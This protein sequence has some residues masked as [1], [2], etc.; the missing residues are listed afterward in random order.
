LWESPLLGLTLIEESFCPDIRFFEF[1]NKGSAMKVR[2][3]VPVR[4]LIVAFGLAAGFVAT[5]AAG[6][7][8]G[9][10]PARDQR[11]S[12]LE[13]QIKELNRKLDDLRK[14]TPVASTTAA[15]DG[16]I[17]TDW[18][19]SLSWR[20]IGPAN[21]G[22]RITA[23]SVFEADP[24]TYWVATASGGLLKTVN[25][26]ITFEHQFDHEATVS[27]GD[28]CVAPSD[29]N[30]VWVG[31][32]E[33]NPRNSVSYGDGV[34][35][36][37]DGGKTWKNMGLKKTYQVGRIVVDPKDPNIVYV[38]ALGR[39]Y[40]PNEERGVFKTADGGRTWTKTLYID[41][42]TGIIDL[43]INPADPKTLLAAA[44]E[45]QRDE[46]DDFLGEPPP[47]D[48]VERYDPVRKYGKG[49]GIYKS[50]D[51]GATWKKMTQGLP[52]CALG[53][54]GLDYYRKDPKVVFAVIDT[55][56]YGT[57]LPP[58]A[59]YMGVQGTEEKTGTKLVD[60]AANSPADQAGLKVSDVLISMDGKPVANQAALVELLRP[61]KVGDKIKAAYQR[62]SEKKEVEVALAARPTPGGGAGGP[63]FPNAGFF[64]EDAEGGALVTE[65]EE[66]GPAAQAGLKIDDV[67]TAVEG[68]PVDRF[69]L[70]IGRLM[71]THRAGDKI[72]ISLTR[73]TEKKDISVPLQ[74]GGFERMRGRN[75]PGHTKRPNNGGLGGQRENIQDQQGPDGFQTGGI[76]KS[77][78]GGETWKRINSLNPRPMYFSQV[79]VDPSDEKIIWV[80]GVSL[81]CSKDG[82]KTFRDE[83]NR[84]LHSDQHALWIDPHNGRHMII[85]CDGGF[86]H[87]YDRA[88][89]WDHLNH[90]ALGQFYHVA[91]DPR[92]LYR[93][94]GGLQD[95]GSWGGPAQM[96][97]STG[98]VNEDWI[99]VGGG[100]GFV[101][102]VDPS[103]PEL[104]YSESQGGAMQ[105]RN[106]KTGERAPIRP[107]RTPGKPAHRFN[108]NTPYIL[109]SHNPSIFYCAGE[110]VWR[111]VKRGDRLRTISPEITRTKKG[112]AT[113]LAESPKNP[114]VL[115]VGTDDG[116]LWITRDGGGKWTEV[117]GKVGLPGPRW[118]ATIEPSRHVEGRAYVAFDAHRSNDDEPYVYVTEDYGETWKSIHG[119][120]PVGSTRVCREDITNQDLLYVGTEFGAWVSANRGVSWTKLNNNLPT[121]AVHEFAQHSTAGEMVAATHGR[122]LWV[123]DVTPLRQ[124]TKETL[125]AK[126]HLYQPNTVVRWHMEQGRD[127]WFSESER[128]FA[129]QNPPRGAQLYYSF[130]P[131]ADKVA[132]KVVDYAGKT[133][134]E[135]PGANTSAGL[136]RI[137]WNLSTGT[138]RA[139]ATAGG[140]GGGRRGGR[141]GAA[142]GTGPQQPPP[143]GPRQR[144]A[145]A[146]QPRAGATQ[147]A[148][149]P[150]VS[151]QEPSAEV[152]SFFGGGPPQVSP[153]TYRLVL[154][155]DGTEL[156]QTLRVVPDPTY[157][158][159]E[160]TAEEEN[161]EFDP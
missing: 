129:G 108:W 13:K 79:R 102:R 20:C 70:V 60:V 24:T 90:L 68:Q 72:K 10:A 116:A 29:K 38:G 134:A 161:D 93:A 54:I 121:V 74:M 55:E 32:G 106:L 96:L 154:T 89:R 97:R 4:G 77:T 86:Y 126:A 41:D 160:I 11:I 61:H 140:P 78:D 56:K 153:G 80:L 73:G 104:V 57:G 138:Q 35:K 95:N 119:N 139:T 21:M 105:R 27:I 44:W 3:L 141:G 46:F 39:L 115:W 109:S 82:G 111:S 63:R 14:E 131:K 69:N 124:M 132:L 67:I 112:S 107:L 22:G 136:H 159:P 152:M 137:A 94:F 62:G 101:C 91:V 133:V 130:N 144:G 37:T 103:D 75:I 149:S 81:Y 114:D 25:N 71:R 145:M 12:E 148:A 158:G 146:Q 135:F 50:T 16:S 8:Q 58:V 9:Q 151:E 150:E 34:Y 156:S 110:Y 147:R 100:D 92:P 142:G 40:G 143:A 83:G 76:Y 53:R 88:E 85:G 18:M 123:L 65:M 120:L 64:A 84:G 26:G 98:P 52:T 31:T 49:A 99:L 87:T 15:P 17:P 43:Q 122:S 113:A 59:V 117:S 5:E 48:G 45:R 128:R 118:V 125:K 19:K 47:P 36:S 7:S 155:V 6:F 157:S 33:N 127:G 51:G 28:V 30:I 23:I 42:K 2:S 1:Y 66:N